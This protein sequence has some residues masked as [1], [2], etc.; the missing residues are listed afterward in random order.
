MS[1]EKEHEVTRTIDK[2][3]RKMESGRKLTIKEQEAYEDAREL[4]ILSNKR[5]SCEYC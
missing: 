5:F 1:I 2:Y 4:L 3:R